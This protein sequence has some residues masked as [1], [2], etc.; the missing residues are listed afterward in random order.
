MSETKNRAKKEI[1]E[2]LGKSGKKVLQA[3]FSARV[4]RLDDG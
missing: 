4:E 1:G 3:E 2:R